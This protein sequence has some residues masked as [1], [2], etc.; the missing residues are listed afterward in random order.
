MAALERENRPWCFPWNARYH[1]W[2]MYCT[3]F[4]M[5]YFPS[6]ISLFLHC[7]DA[8]CALSFTKEH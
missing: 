6:L 4:G 7:S 3:T 5:L 1:I 8:N 2:R